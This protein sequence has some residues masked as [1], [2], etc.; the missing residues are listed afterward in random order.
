MEHEVY[1]SD[2]KDVEFLLSII[3]VSDNMVD[4]ILIDH[5]ILFLTDSTLVLSN[6]LNL[7][8]T[9]VYPGLNEIKNR[10]FYNAK[11]IYDVYVENCS[12]VSLEGIKYLNIW[13]DLPSVEVDGLKVKLNPLHN[14]CLKDDNSGVEG[15]DYLWNYSLDVITKS[16][17]PIIGIEKIKKIFINLTS[18][19]VSYILL[20]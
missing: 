20:N 10:V 1:T 8:N 3:R 5:N 9:F 19:P 13:T 18:F 4:S 12:I 11:I 14:I 17:L 15:F 7:P 16:Q 6:A 2:T